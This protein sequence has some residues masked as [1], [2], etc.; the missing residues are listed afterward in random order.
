MYLVFDVGVLGSKGGHQQDVLV[1]AF[2]CSLSHASECT[3]FT[4]MTV[5]V[6]KAS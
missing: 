2:S 1:E 4:Y 3:Q 5:S 6:V